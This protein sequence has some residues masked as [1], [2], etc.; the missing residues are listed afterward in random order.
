MIHDEAALASTRE[1]QNLLDAVEESGALLIVGDPQQKADRRR[2]TVV[3]ARAAADRQES[4]AE[5]TTN[6]RARDPDDQRDQARFR[7]GEQ[8]QAL[9]GYAERGRLHQAPDQGGRDRALEAAHRDRTDGQATLV[10]TQTSNEHLDELNARAQALRARDRQLGYNSLKL[11]G[12][13]YELRPGDE[14][15]IRHTVTLPP[16]PR[17][18]RNPGDGHRDRPACRAAVNGPPRRRP[19]AMDREQSRRRPAPRLRPAPGARPGRH[20]PTPRT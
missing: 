8:Q 11:P 4:R 20:R 15:Q 7:D 17:P 14:V 3:T 12:R 6:L 13:P 10:I 19:I 16:R 5:L 9:G 1:Q 18:Q 2:R